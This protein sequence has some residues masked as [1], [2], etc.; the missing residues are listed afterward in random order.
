M[1]GRD[2]EVGVPWLM[3]DAGFVA[4]GRWLEVSAANSADEV[5]AFSTAF[6]PPEYPSGKD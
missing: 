3:E 6:D 5:E 1:L 2:R 4:G